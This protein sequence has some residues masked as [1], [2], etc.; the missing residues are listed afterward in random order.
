V[1]IGAATVNA[2][3][4]ALSDGDT[5]S[6]NNEQ[7]LPSSGHGRCSA[8]CG[9]VE[10][11]YGTRSGQ[12]PPSTT[13]DALSTRSVSTSA[14]SPLRE[15]STGQVPLAGSYG[16][17]G[18]T[19][20]SRVGLT[21]PVGIQRPATLL[22]S[23]EAGDVLHQLPFTGFAALLVACAGAM[24]LLVGLAFRHVSAGGPAWPRV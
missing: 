16:A 9:S 6:Q 15:L 2:P 17:N 4:R 3:V 21:S 8:S 1:Q 7:E 13:P 18:R 14:I 5:T 23:D 20:V 10:L 24:A 11:A 12:S 19:G 22:G